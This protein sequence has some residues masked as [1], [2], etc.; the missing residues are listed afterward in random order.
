MNTVQVRYICLKHPELTSSCGS[1]FCAGITNS[2]RRQNRL[3]KTVKNIELSVFLYALLGRWC[4]EASYLDSPVRVIVTAMLGVLN[5]ARL[6]VN[7]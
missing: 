5:L 2:S 7:T 4:S 1:L 3:L 6:P